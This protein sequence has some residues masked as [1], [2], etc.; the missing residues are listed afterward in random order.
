MK[1]AYLVFGYKNPQLIRKTIEY[2]SSED[3]S[4]FVHI[5][6]KVPIAQFEC[7][8]GKYVTFLTQRVPV[9]WA[10]FSG[11][12]AILLLIRQALAAP[13]VYDYFVLLSG[14]EFPLRSRHF[15]H[16]FLHLNR[17]SEYITMVKMP[18]PGKP[19]SRLNRIRYPSTRPILRF[20]FRGLGKVGLAQRDYK[21][22]FGPLEP[23][24]GNTWWTLS[25]DACQYVEEFARGDRNLT[26]FCETIHAPEETFIH[27]IIGNSPF[28]DRVRR[29][30]VYEDWPNG[31]AH[32]RTLTGQHIEYFASQPEVN[33]ENR[34]NSGELLFARKINDVQLPLVDNIM[35][36][37]EQKEKHATSSTSAAEV[38]R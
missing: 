38:S 32:P 16:Q 5:D 25:R 19:L 27:T 13:E 35:K 15:I 6:A 21:P 30:L 8:R 31:A 20:V 26:K 28:R 37:I 23:Y 14:S 22:H 36:M 2:L 29:N 4:F 12:R 1:I 9:Y 7:V 11:V 24:S 10:E 34:H 17:G 3:A 33:V 18:A